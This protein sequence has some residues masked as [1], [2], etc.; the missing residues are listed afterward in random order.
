[1]LSA[2]APSTRFD[3]IFKSVSLS[4]SCSIRITPSCRDGD[5]VAERVLT[6]VVSIV[7]RCNRL[8]YI[9]I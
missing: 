4:L 9:I 2:R 7:G 5:Y 1:M 8:A 6:G 3:A